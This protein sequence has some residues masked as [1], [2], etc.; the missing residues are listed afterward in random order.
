MGADFFNLF[1]TPK[2]Q[3]VFIRD[4]GEAKGGRKDNDMVYGVLF[5]R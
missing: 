2:T 3:A 5:D 4:L 1:L